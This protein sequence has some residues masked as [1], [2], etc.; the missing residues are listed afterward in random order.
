MP[1][2]RTIHSESTPIRSAIGPLETTRSG[3]LWPRPTMRAVRAGATRPSSSLV[4]SVVTVSG[5]DGPRFVRRIGAGLRRS[6]D[7][8]A[9]DDPLREPRQHLARPDLDE[10]P[11]AGVVHRGEGLTPAD[12]ADQG[13]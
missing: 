5:M 2:R 6:L 12:G 13:A 10:A 4:V 1:V 8:G 3:S 7:L 9:G 11:R